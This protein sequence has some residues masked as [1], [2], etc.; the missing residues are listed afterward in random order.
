MCIRAT[1]PSDGIL[2]LADGHMQAAQVEWSRLGPADFSAIR[3]KQDL[4]MTV[5]SRYNLSHW[6]AVQEVENWDARVRG[7][8]ARSVVHYP[9]RVFQ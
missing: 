1:D 3:N 6:V 4:I 2:N 8:S 5:G 7:M 9:A